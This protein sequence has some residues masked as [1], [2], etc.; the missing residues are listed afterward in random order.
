[1]HLAEHDHMVEAFPADRA[2]KPFDVAILPRRAWRYR[3]VA[4]PHRLQ[5]ARD[6]GAV[7]PV[8]TEN[9]SSDLVMM[10]SAKYGA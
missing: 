9:L 10:K 4:D 7:K 8:C 1:M 2:D 3:M 6:D 5:S